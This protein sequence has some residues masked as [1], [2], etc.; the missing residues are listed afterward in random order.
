MPTTISNLW[1][2]GTVLLE[3]TQHDNGLHL[4][5]HPEPTVMRHP[6]LVSGSNQLQFSPDVNSYLKSTTNQH[7]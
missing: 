3:Q 2:A 7:H 6:E 5:C 4:A 1:H